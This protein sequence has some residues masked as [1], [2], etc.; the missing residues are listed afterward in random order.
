MTTDRSRPAGDRVRASA[1]ATLGGC[2]GAGIG[3][4]AGLFVG[5]SF[6]FLFAWLIDDR[7]TSPVGPFVLV[8]AALLGTTGGLG[9]GCSLALRL[10]GAP[11]ARRAGRRAG[12]IAFVGLLVVYTAQ[13]FALSTGVALNT[14]FALSAWPWVL[15]PVVAPLLAVALTGRTDATDERTPGTSRERAL[16]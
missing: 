16:R 7:T 1:A 5:F 6:G 3:L 10:A 11:A 4:A 9:Y 14:D 8:V 13:S 15:V 12:G 2:L